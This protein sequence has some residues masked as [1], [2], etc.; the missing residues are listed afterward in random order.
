MKLFFAFLAALLFSVCARAALVGQPAPQLSIYLPQ[1]KTLKLS[2]YKGKT[3]AILLF[4]TTCDHCQATIKNLIPLQKEF[5]AKGFQVISAAI[6]DGADTKRFIATYKP[7]FPLGGMDHHVAAAYMGFTPTTQAFVPFLILVDAAG[8]VQGQ[9][10]GGDPMLKAD[11]Q[12]VNLRAAVM[13][14]LDHAKTGA[15]PPA[16]AGAPATKP[17]AK[18]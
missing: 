7:N 1:N 4:V 6:D 18:K 13:A 15:K 8:I 3:V 14:M 16:K 10:T 9:F 12:A 5:G 2:D 17:A 11:A